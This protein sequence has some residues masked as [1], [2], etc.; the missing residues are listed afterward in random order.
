VEM[1]CNSG[2]QLMRKPSRQILCPCCN[3]RPRDSATRNGPTGHWCMQC[4]DEFDSIDWDALNEA[5]RDE[6]L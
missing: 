1:V 2:G 5:I 6:G 3:E 4:Q